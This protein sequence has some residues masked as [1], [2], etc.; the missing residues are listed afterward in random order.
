MVVSNGS[1]ALSSPAASSP[2]FVEDRRLSHHTVV[3]Q[4]RPTSAGRG[5]DWDGSLDRP[6]GIGSS[7]LDV[8][9]HPG[10]SF[11][12][13]GWT[14]SNETRLFGGIRGGTFPLIP[15]R[16]GTSPARDE[17]VGRTQSKTKDATG[18]EDVAGPPYQNL[19]VASSA[20][21]AGVG[22]RPTG[23]QTAVPGKNRSRGPPG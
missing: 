7:R 3:P 22:F 18:G 14:P 8:F 15:R 4:H 19:L 17:E 16:G 10:F 1:P 6:L 2:S 9:S 23:S 12:I 13:V 11:H 21:W 5:V 20:C